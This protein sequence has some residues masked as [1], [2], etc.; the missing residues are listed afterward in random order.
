MEP[1]CSIEKEKREERVRFESVYSSVIAK[2]TSK[3]RSKSIKIFLRSCCI[4]VMEMERVTE[5]PLGPVDIR[6]RKRQ[7]LGWDVGPQTTK[8]RFM[9]NW[10]KGHL[11]KCWNVGTMKRR[12]LLPLKLYVELRNIV[13]Q[14]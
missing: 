1:D 11:A 12:N 14:P 5:F 7:R 13:M 9:E 10:V 4:P 8:R 3:S 2:F 6:P